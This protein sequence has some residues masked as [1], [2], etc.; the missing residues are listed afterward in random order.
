VRIQR[1]NSAPKTKKRRRKR[2]RRRR[3]RR[4][5]EGGG[6]RR[7]KKERNEGREKRGEKSRREGEGGTTTNALALSRVSPPPTLS[8][9]PFSLAHLS[10]FAG[11]VRPRTR[12]RENL[13]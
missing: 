12:T 1:T 9:S 2:R 13:D 4:G 5:G 6:G 3:R 7:K 11:D 10:P 8:I